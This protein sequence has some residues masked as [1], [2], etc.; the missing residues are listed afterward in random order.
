[1]RDAA[2][3]P[4][5]INAGLRHQFFERHMAISAQ[6]HDMAHI[7]VECRIVAFGQKAQTPAVLLPAFPQ[8]PLRPK[9][10]RRLFAEHPLQ[11]FERRIAVGPGLAMADRNLP[12]VGKTGFQRRIGLAFHHRDLVA[13]LGQIP[14]GAGADDAGTDHNNMHKKSCCAPALK[15]AEGA[16]EYG[17]RLNCAV[18]NWPKSITKQPKG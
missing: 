6:G 13:A 18:A 1:M 16:G 4:V 7:A 10:Q 9:Q 11:R 12:G 8:R 5:V 3:Q 15:T 14:G 2:L 17:H